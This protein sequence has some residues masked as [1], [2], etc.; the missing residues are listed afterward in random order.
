ME[1]DY[2][3]YDPEGP[4]ENEIYEFD[5]DNLQWI[6]RNETLPNG[7]HSHYA[8]FVSDEDFVCT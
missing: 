3:F 6:E 1:G 4:T 2:T 7:T 8:T 5:P